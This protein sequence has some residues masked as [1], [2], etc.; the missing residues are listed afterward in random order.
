MSTKT[1]K[2]IMILALYAVAL[3]IGFRT[4]EIYYRMRNKFKIEK[5]KLPYVDILKYYYI[6][7]TLPM[8]GYKEVNFIEV[9]EKDV[10]MKFFFNKK[11][12]PLLK[13]RG[14]KIYTQAGDRIY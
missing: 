8:N 4:G 2:I 10:R 12:R 3:F 9:H 14:I 6:V 5:V 11:L 13:Q 1:R 7:E